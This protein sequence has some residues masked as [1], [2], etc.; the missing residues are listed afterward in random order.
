MRE[1]VNGLRI[2]SDGKRFKIQGEKKWWIFSGWSDWGEL[3]GPGIVKTTYFDTLE[4]ANEKMRDL[5]LSGFQPHHKWKVI[6][7]PMTVRK[8]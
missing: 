3:V 8:H 1:K 7:T 5:C 2:L 4:N 6:G